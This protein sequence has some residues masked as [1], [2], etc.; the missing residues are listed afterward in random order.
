MKFGP[1]RLSS[2]I[3]IFHLPRFYVLYKSNQVRNVER[4]FNELQR[5]ESHSKELSYLKHQYGK[6]LVKVVT[7]EYSD[8]FELEV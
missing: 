5:S 4:L 6:N 1:N 7:E 8:V 3:T 2:L